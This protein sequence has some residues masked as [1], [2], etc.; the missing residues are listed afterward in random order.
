VLHE[1]AGS[2]LTSNL[3][4]ETA[5]LDAARSALRAGQVAEAIAL[6]DD[7][8]RRFQNGQLQHEAS[9][10]RVEAL[11]ALGDRTSAEVVARALVASAPKSFAAHRVKAMINW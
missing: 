11:L 10:I 7:C 5:A 3:T 9:A 8:T 4:E 6:L 1:F 2:A